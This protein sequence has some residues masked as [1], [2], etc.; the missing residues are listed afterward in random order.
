[1]KP[2]LSPKFS[3]Y[4]MLCNILIW[5]LRLLS[6]P[7]EMLTHVDVG[8]RYFGFSGLLA[9]LLMAADAWW[10]GSSMLYLLMTMVVLRVISHRVWCFWSRTAGYTPVNSRSAGRPLLGVFVPQIPEIAMRWIEPVLVMI[11]ALVVCAIS[12]TLGGYLMWSGFALLGVTIARASLSYNEMLDR[13]D[14]G[15][16]P[17]LPVT[18]IPESIPDRMVFD[19]IDAQLLEAQ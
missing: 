3:V 18:S 14:A 10:E 13:L 12:S 8:E 19:R 1:M 16:M 4:A 2:E 17:A 6:V 9:V 11:I 7:V 15:I 5:H